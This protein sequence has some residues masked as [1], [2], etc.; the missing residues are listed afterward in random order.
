MHCYTV[1]QVSTVLNMYLM[2]ASFLIFSYLSTAFIQ[3]LKYLNHVRDIRNKI[4]EKES[5]HIISSCRRTLAGVTMGV[6]IW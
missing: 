1:E 6:C 4:D 3:D 5:F 2:Q